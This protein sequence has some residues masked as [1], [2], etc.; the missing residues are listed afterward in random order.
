MCLPQAN[1][2]EPSEVVILEDDANKGD[3][4]PELLESNTL[5]AEN[6][7]ITVMEE[8][9]VASP[10]AVLTTDAP[11]AGSKCCLPIDLASFSM[12]APAPTCASGRS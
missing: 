10:P 5:A 1:A 9:V 8:S 11:E 4:L 12:T 2:D 6:S 7:D 3:V